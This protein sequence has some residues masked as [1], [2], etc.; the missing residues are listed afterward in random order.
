M[1]HRDFYYRIDFDL[2]DSRQH[3]MGDDELAHNGSRKWRTKTAH[4]KDTDN[5]HHGMKHPNE[6]Q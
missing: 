1:F 2:Y 6:V 3:H 5:F 4:N